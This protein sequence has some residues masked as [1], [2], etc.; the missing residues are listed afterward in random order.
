MATATLS[1]EECQ[2]RLNEAS[3]QYMRDEIGEEAY[4]NAKRQF[5]PDYKAGLLAL[6]DSLTRSA[7][8]DSETPVAEVPGPV[9]LVMLLA[10]IFLALMLLLLRP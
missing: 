9:E 2:Q 4:E 10:A 8:N 6:G 3:A 5:A 7:A 1:A